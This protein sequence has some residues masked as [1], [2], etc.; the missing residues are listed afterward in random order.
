MLVSALDF[1]RY[2]HRTYLISAGDTLSAQKAVALE[3]AKARSA[4]SGQVHL[5]R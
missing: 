1:S 2:A 4:T 5:L 3:K